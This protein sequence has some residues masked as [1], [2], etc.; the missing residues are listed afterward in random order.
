MKKKNNKKGKQN[1]AEDMLIDFSEETIVDDSIE[2]S[3][4]IVEEIV[5]EET[6]NAIEDA[7]EQEAI[8]S[9]SEDVKETIV[10]E[11]SAVEESVIKDTTAEGTVMEEVASE[12]ENG[13]FFVEIPNE[14]NSDIV[15][16]TFLYTPSEEVGKELKKERRRKI[17]KEAGSG[18]KRWIAPVCALVIILAV[19]IGFFVYES[20]LV[21]GVVHVEAGV[22]VNVADL[23][24]KEDENAYFTEDSDEINP[25]IPGE[26]HLK[27]HTGGMNHK[28]TV[29]VEDTTEPEVIAKDILDVEYGSTC[30]PDAFIQKINDATEVTVSF[31][32]QP[33]FGNMEIQEISLTATDLGNNTVTVK[34]KLRVSRVLTYLELEAGSAAPSAKDFMISEND[35]E[36]NIVTDLSE[37]NFN[38][39][40]EHEIV[41]EAEG[42]EY[43]SVIAVVDTVAPVF[44]VKDI[45]GYALVKRTPESFLVVPE[46]ALSDAS[47]EFLSNYPTVDI[48]NTVFTF[49]SEPD[50]TKIGTQE[51]TIIGTDEGGNTC[52]KTAKLTLKEDTEDPTISG[53]DF[54][55]YLGDS[56]SYKSKVSV[57][58][59]CMEDLDVKVDSSKV[60]TGT[61]GTYPVTYTVTDAAGHSATLTVNMTIKKHTYDVNELN[62]MADR[63]LAKIITPDMSKYDQ[64]W[65]I[66]TYIRGHV[67]YISESEKGDWVRSAFEGLNTGKGDCYV[68]ASVSKLLL[69]RAGITNMD[70]ERIP[71][72]NSMHYWN[73][74]DI[75]DGHGWYHFDTTPRKDH[76]TIFLWDDATIK[77]YSDAH[78]NCHNYDRT[79]YP[80]IN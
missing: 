73:L 6:Q 50:L 79:K 8:E 62:D 27:I 10:E 71:S 26:Y 61:E 37:I 21:Y 3:Q 39:V 53:S 78:K 76:P 17:R 69:T 28:C 38:Q 49:E 13:P 54:V 74:V 64:A 46:N 58:D 29:F 57:K 4:E 77:A 33:D 35:K 1:S 9:L 47:E 12:E 41:I 25:A 30:E 70:I 2:V 36:G 65:A 40:G 32:N 7:L 60:D 34:S 80:T 45:D 67:A 42:V 20:G 43:N 5:K 72:G 31:V 63:I 24:V 68:Y 51:V 44:E 52:T 56:I 16:G 11:Q 59:N 19:G 15:V 66:F 55:V 14:G 75:E 22:I 23:L 18:L 48:T